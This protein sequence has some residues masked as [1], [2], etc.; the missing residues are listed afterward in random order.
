VA[1]GRLIGDAPA[2]V[3][4]LRNERPWLEHLAL[5]RDLFSDPAVADVLWPGR[6]GGARSEAQISEIL[7]ADISHW[8]ERGFGPWVFFERATGMFVGRGGLRHSTIAGVECVEVLYALRRDAWGRGYATEIALLAV[9]EGR[10]LG[11]AE[12]CGLVSPG[13]HAS[14]R[15]LEK[16]GIRF[17]ATIEHAGRPHL[18]GSVRAMH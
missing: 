10:R 2:R 9:G 8:Q 12:V 4:S 3:R 17:E 13:N 15:V 7:S 11:L 18:L 6:L 16:A 5:Y 1:G 14:R